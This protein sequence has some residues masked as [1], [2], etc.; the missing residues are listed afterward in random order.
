MP[1]IHTESVSILVEP[2]MYSPVIWMNSILF[3]LVVHLKR[4]KSKISQDLMSRFVKTLFE[5]D[6]NISPMIRSKKLMLQ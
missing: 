6:A 2:N 1:I 5:L 3:L 4:A